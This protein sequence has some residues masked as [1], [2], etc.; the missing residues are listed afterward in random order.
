MRII[1]TLISVAIILGLAFVFFFV[2]FGSEKRTLFQM[3]F[4]KNLTVIVEDE[5]Q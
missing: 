3:I 1:R 2:P 4:N 5:N